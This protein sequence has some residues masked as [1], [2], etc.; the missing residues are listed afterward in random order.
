MN[1]FERLAMLMKSR[2]EKDLWPELERCSGI[3]QDES[4]AIAM[5]I[6]WTLRLLTQEY[7]E[8]RLP[9]HIIL[10]SRSRGE[11]GFKEMWATHVEDIPSADD[12]SGRIMT[13]VG[14]VWRGRG[15]DPYV[16]KKVLSR[17]PGQSEEP[18]IFIQ[19]VVI[20]L[21]EFDHESIR[22]IGKRAPSIVRIMQRGQLDQTRSL[23][24]R[25]SLG[26]TN[27]DMVSSFVQEA[28]NK[29][30]T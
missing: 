20:S 11:K 27:K 30:T 25:L 4:L 2:A 23:P 6:L 7:N 13:V 29:M 1:F 9:S 16:V 12:Q 22:F 15:V 21:V 19:Q 3:S 10:N 17:T 28:I 24:D 26:R 18:T 14:K 5:S 8:Q